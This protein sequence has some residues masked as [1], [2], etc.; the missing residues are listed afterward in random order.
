MKIHT[1]LKILEP[2][3]ANKYNSF[4]GIMNNRIISHSRGSYYIK[5]PIFE[6][7]LTLL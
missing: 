6:T 5:K 7:F 2:I 4:D 1:V 3:I